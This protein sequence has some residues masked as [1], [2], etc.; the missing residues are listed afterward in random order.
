MRST[1]RPKNAEKSFD[2]VRVSSRMPVIRNPLSTKN[3]CTPTQP[4]SSQAASRLAPTPCGSDSRLK[5]CMTTSRMAR[6]RTPSSAGMRCGSG[7]QESAAALVRTTGAIHVDLVDADTVDLTILEAHPPFAIESRHERVAALHGVDQLALARVDE[8]GGSAAVEQAVPAPE[9]VEE[10]RL[11]P[12]GHRA[13]PVAPRAVEQVVGHLTEVIAPTGDVEDFT[14]AAW[15]EVV[16]V[17]ADDL[18]VGVADEHLAELPRRHLLVGHLEQPLQRSAVVLGSE[19][20]ALEE[21]LRG[22]HDRVDRQLL[23]RR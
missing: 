1:R 21:L 8:H 10:S 20:G 16:E 4:R 19:G 23:S 2:D 15:P 14:V 13:R 12:P 17:P 3:S 7:R 6:P 9:I 18:G 22:V 5:L 11:E